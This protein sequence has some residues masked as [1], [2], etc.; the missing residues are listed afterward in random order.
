MFD[1]I[2]TDLET[3]ADVLARFREAPTLRGLRYFLLNPSAQPAGFRWDFSDCKCCGIGLTVA[4]LQLSQDVYGLNP[5][6]W[7][8]RLYGIAQEDADALFGREMPVGMCGE[9]PSSG[10]ADA[11][12]R[13]LAAEP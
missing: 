8:A 12:D 9:V 10:L 11:I 2:P 4:L 5:W 1:C 3:P 7:V 6:K 13:Y